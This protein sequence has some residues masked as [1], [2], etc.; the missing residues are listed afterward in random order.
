MLITSPD[1]VASVTSG[2]CETEFGVAPEKAPI[3]RED[4]KSAFP[5]VEDCC[6]SDDESDPSDIPGLA[7]DKNTEDA[8]PISCKDSCC[9]NE[10]KNKC[11]DHSSNDTTRAKGCC[12]TGSDL[13]IPT[14]ESSTAPPCCEGKT[15]PCCD[16]SCLD[17]LALREC[18]TKCSTT[19]HDGSSP[20][21][22]ILLPNAIK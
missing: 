20:T 15:S 21:P 19:K 12:D 22:I 5:T 6:T 14:V 13:E 9:A 17:R 3:E 1:E 16:T 4:P 10:V 8:K 7:I 2:L 11:H 18:Q